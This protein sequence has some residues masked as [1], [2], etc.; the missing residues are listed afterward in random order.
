[1]QVLAVFFGWQIVRALPMRFHRL[2]VVAASL[3]IGYNLAAWLVFLL[4]LIVGWNFGLPLATMLILAGSL[5]S[6]FKWR[7]RYE[8]VP[9]PRRKGWIK[10]A[11]IILAALIAWVMI[12]LVLA[13][14][15]FPAVGDWYSNGNVWGDSPLHVGLANQFAHGDTVDMVSPIYL[16]VPLAYPIMGDFWSGVLLRLT[17][18]WFWA[19]TI[20]TMTMLLATLQ[21]IFS[22]GYR[23]LGSLK[24][25]WLQFLMITFSGSLRGAFILGN[26]LL[27]R[28][29]TAYNETVGTSLAF[30]TGDNYLNFVNSHLLPQRAYL[31]GMGF[32]IIAASILLHIYKE[33]R[34]HHINREATLRLGLIGGV[35]AG[36]LPLIHTH[37]F[38]VLLGVM[39]LA[40]GALAYRGRGH[41]PTPW[42]LMLITTMALAVPQ[43]YWQFR[44]TYNSHFGHWIFGWMMQNFELRPNDNWFGF[45]FLNVGFLFVAALAGWYFLRRYRAKA[46]LW[47]AYVA[48][49]SIFLICNIY[50]FQPS[51][52]DN[53]KF[54]EYGFW[55]IMI[56][57][58]FVLTKW[59]NSLVGKVAVV[60][61][62][63]SL[64][65]MGFFA[66][67]LSGGN[68]LT[69]QIL[70]SQDV[71]VG[72]YVQKNLP[73][74]AYILVGDQHNNPVT[75]LGDRK[76]LMTFSG[77][78]NL[79]GADWATTLSD[80]G[81]MLG[82]KDGAED[83]IRSYGLNYAIFNLNEVGSGE[84][85]L[86]YYEQ[87]FSLEYDLNGW[88][89]FNLQRSPGS[90][91]K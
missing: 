55:F 4:A 82:G 24:G 89:I 63:L 62:M 45:W 77:W 26:V 22:F 57:I 36:S 64:C 19:M 74:D 9:M 13:S 56:A 5:W 79:Y 14:Y 75:M 46:E 54:F 31:F 20:P 53:M 3:V 60:I 38:M 51:T 2:E 76:V 67:V 25:A 40:T 27:T 87:H 65:T 1:M 59:W 66:L 37:S 90:V 68:Q 71:A 50:V 15:N 52:W 41:V 11:E 39:I 49:V 84:A 86:D 58:A 81:A 16:K 73:D 35:I 23:L 83:L 78:Y 33:T 8:I 80:R 88:Y 7:S 10:W 18:S 30:A 69:F 85:N 21:L 61:V 91:L 44:T 43:L 32:F 29:F 17:D 70:S 12:N 34:L 42:W 48:G 47:L 72:Q 6:H 28:G